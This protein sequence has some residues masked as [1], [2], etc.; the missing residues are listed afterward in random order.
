MSCDVPSPCTRVCRIDA[1]TGL[2]LG[3]R[4][5][6]AEI[7]SWSAMSDEEKRVVLAALS[8]RSGQ[9]DLR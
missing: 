5:T 8:A 7:A 3:C 9:L 4:R 6:L 2:C 1:G